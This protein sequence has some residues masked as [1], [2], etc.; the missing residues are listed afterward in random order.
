MFQEISLLR[1]P[2]RLYSAMSVSSFM[3]GFKD[4]EL[5]PAFGPSERYGRIHH[6]LELDLAIKASQQLRIMHYI[7]VAIQPKES[8]AVKFEVSLPKI[9]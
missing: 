4:I 1:G 9:F 5:K 8:N 7:W 6:A 2:R 3:G